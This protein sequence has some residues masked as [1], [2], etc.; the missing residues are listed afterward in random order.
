V[1]IFPEGI[2]N[3]KKE[4]ARFKEGLV[5]IAYL[6]NVPIYPIYIDP[7]HKPLHFQHVMLGKPINLQSQY[8][9]LNTQTCKAMTNS[10]YDYVNSMKQQLTQELKK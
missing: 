10:L 4:L 8:S 6:A 9:E 7:K 5:T 1:L 3:R 2:M